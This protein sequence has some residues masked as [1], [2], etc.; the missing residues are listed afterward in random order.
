MNFS[1]DVNADN[2]M[3]LKEDT[4]LD[5]RYKIVKRVKAGGMGAVYQVADLNMDNRIMALKQMLDSFKDPQERRDSIDRF[6]SEIQVLTG[7]CHP[8]IPRVTDNFVSENSFF[9]V[10]DFIEGRDLSNIL[11]HEGNP[12]LGV[13]YVTKVGIEL[14]EALKYI[15]NL[16]VPVAHRD[17][18]PSNILVRDCD[19]RIM[20]I[21]FGIARVSNPGEGFWIGTPGYAPPEQQ[22][23]YPEPRSDI[24]ALGATMHELLTGHRPT[25]FE[26][27]AF[28]DFGVEVPQ[29]LANIIYD[30][31]A[32]TPDER[33]QSAGEMQERLIAELGY[34]PLS[35]CNDDSFVFTESV[36]KF[37]SE[38]LS[39]LLND[40]IKRYENERYTSF[41]PQNLDYLVV[42]LACPTKFELIIKKNDS[43]KCIEFYEK[44]GILSPSLLERINPASATEKD[45]KN[46][47]D[48]FISD[49]ENFKSGSWMIM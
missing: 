30:S 23:G 16:E 8:N 24:Y 40:L 22:A 43:S 31:L 49:Y 11:K 12:G 48:K 6:V 33:I 36:N 10:M 45:A 5:G 2:G 20:L 39:P 42:T 29:G 3:W 34:N 13:E 1:T 32:W 26:F 17:I 25:D 37:H 27:L 21:D 4:V 9:F 41:I 46:L 19:S 35:Y 7:I 15:H 28:E 14:C 38:I 44:E 47:V 18:K